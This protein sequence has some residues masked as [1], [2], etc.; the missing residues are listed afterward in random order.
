MIPVNKNIKKIRTYEPGKSGKT[1]SKI[2]YIKLS[3]NESPLSFNKRLIDN[4]KNK[5]IPL[6]KYPDPMCSKLKEKISKI[7]K[8]NK[9]NIIFGNGSMKS[10]T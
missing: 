6:S 3:S 8:I 7:Y 2:K 10:F 4:V 1:K 9:K 5:K